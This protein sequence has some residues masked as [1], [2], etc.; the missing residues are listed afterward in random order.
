MCLILNACRDATLRLK[1]LELTRPLTVQA[2][3][4]KTLSYEAQLHL[5]RG[6][7]T[8]GKADQAHPAS[9]SRRPPST[10]PSRGRGRGRPQRGRGRSG[11]R[12]GRGGTRSHRS[13]SPSPGAPPPPS[14]SSGL[15]RKCLEKSHYARECPKSYSELTCTKCDEEGHLNGS[16]YCADTAQCIRA[17]KGYQGA[18]SSKLM[19]S[20][21]TATTPYASEDSDSSCALVCR[22]VRGT[23]RAR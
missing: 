1:L 3:T 7:S 13:R 4:D 16:P 22:L 18:Q 19:H 14:P 17:A 20:S 15:C 8:G 23:T 21:A 10:A 6:L 11:R 5:N 9:S 12:A 2:I